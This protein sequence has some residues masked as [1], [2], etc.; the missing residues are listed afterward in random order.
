MGSEQTET[1]QVIGARR[2]LRALYL[3]AP[4]SVVDDVSRLVE[5]AFASLHRTTADQDDA[6]PVAEKE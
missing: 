5:A 3:E 4:A 6:T 1:P 2:G